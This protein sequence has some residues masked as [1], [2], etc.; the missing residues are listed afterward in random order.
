MPETFKGVVTVVMK[1]FRI[2]AVLCLLP[3]A[4]VLAAQNPE[5]IN[6]DSLA[7]IKTEAS[8]QPQLMEIARNITTVSGPR[9][10]NSANV[11]AAG[12]YARKKLVE[13]K[14]DDVHLETWNFGNGWVNER[15][16]IKVASDPAMTLLAYPKAWTP[17]TNGPIT[18]DVIAADVRTEAD[19]TRFRGMLKGK[20]VLILP[21]PPSLP[22]PSATQ[23]AVKRFSDDELL[24]LAGAQPAPAPAPAPAA[25]SRGGAAAAPQ[26]I[27]APEP[28]AGFFAW[29]E[30]ALSAAPAQP[31]GALAPKPANNPATQGITR[32]R[33]T[34]FF[35]EEGVLAMLEPGPVRDGAILTVSATGEPNPW[36]TDPKT[37]KVPPQIVIAADQ[38]SK[39]MQ[40]VTKSSPV[41][42]VSMTIDVKNTYI[43]ADPLAFNV[44][45]DIKGTD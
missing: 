33:A 8:R 13:W 22:A 37:P 34:K 16:S 10:T 36:K 30:N 20:I 2:I 32:D 38:Y 42:P 27:P 3:L 23:T 5:K 1:L 18:A 31:T 14:L 9:L 17:G 7:K 41:S 25:A 11:R 6:L 4:L 39:I 15:F 21:A 45:A 43:T 19:I 40:M 44:V 29:V 24:K 26:G 12:E 28:E 35:L